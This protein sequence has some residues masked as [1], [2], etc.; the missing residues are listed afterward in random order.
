MKKNLEEAIK[1]TNMPALFQKTELA[2][3]DYELAYDKKLLPLQSSVSDHHAKVSHKEVSEILRQ[4]EL[5]L[6]SGKKR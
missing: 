1:Q 5:H 6:H 2:V 4:L 3:A